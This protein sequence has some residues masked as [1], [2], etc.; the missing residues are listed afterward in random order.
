MGVVNDVFRLMRAGF[1]QSAQTNYAENL[2]QSADLAEQFSNGI[3]VTHGAAGANPFANMAAYAGMI[4]GSGTV[5]G[6]RATGQV[7]AG[8]SVYLVDFE[9]TL[10]DRASYQ[11]QYQ[12]VIAQAALPNWQ[13]GAMYP[14]RVSPEDQ[15]AIMLG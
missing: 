4:Q 11:A 8:T 10:P 14:L 9:I 6:L 2:R 5:R 3:P 12:T 7:I 1:K 15:N 13:P